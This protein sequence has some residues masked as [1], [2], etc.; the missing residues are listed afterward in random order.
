MSDQ[1]DKT[2]SKPPKQIM[3]DGEMYIEDKGSRSDD[4]V[5]RDKNDHNRNQIICPKFQSD[6]CKGFECKCTIRIPN[7]ATQ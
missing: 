3:I 6:C 1:S 2:E 7:C 4:I 5:E